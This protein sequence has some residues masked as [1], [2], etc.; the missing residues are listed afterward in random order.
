MVYNPI[1]NKKI[2]LGVT[3]G[4]AAYKAVDLTSRLVKA[5][6]QV[7]VIMTPNA[8]QFVTPLTFQAI[9]HRP[10]VTEMFSLLAETEI[11]HV[12]LGKRADIVVV[13][14][15]T[16]NT[17]AKLSLGLADD[18]LSTT[19]L[20][21]RAPILIAPAMESAMWANTATQQHISVLRDRGVRIVGPAEG[22]LASGAVGMGR[23]SEPVEIY[24]A[25]GLLLAQSGDLKGRTIVITAG[26]T[27]EPI[28]PVRFIGNHSSGKMGYALA[29]AARD[30]GADVILIS[31]PVA[32]RPPSGLRIQHV[33]T[34]QEMAQAVLDNVIGSDA[35]IMAAAVADYR[36][37]QAVL[38]KIKKEA[39]DELVVQLV[40]NPDILAE[41]ARWR[42][43]R[44]LPVVIGFAAET[45]DLIAHAQ[46]K[47]RRKNLDM[48][49]ANDITA[50]GSG[51][52]TD[53]N[54]VTLLG[55]NGL[56]ERLPLL[57]KHEVAH[58]ILD[59]MKE[60]LNAPEGPV[61]N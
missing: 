19:V 58:R 16:A 51:F 57:S 35:L 55:R 56:M 2:V 45:Q 40:R 41:V 37:K 36:A 4:I 21:T 39:Q 54:Q 7:D 50:E 32:L 1:Q 24:E 43:E 15:A 61:K 52:G 13:A 29:E 14:P 25:I 9:T 26:G 47:L 60:L 22:R 8:Q 11:G 20:A 46:D 33:N 12:S 34:A 59:E 10:V 38:Q 3:G 49:V 53:T 30:R 42:E 31:A 28:D 48:I 27:R 18:M 23:M 17:I 44:S 5:G 6:A